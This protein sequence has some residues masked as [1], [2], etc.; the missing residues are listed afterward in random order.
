MKINFLIR[1]STD[2]QDMK[3]QRADIERIKQKYGAEIVRVIPLEGVSGTATLDD[4]QVQQILRELENPDIDGLGL[5]ALDRLF[6]PGKGFGQYV[7][8]DRFIHT[9]K[10]MWTVQEGEVDPATNEGA[11]KCTSAFGHAGAEWRRIRQNT[12][13]GRRE[14]LAIGRPINTTPVY[15]H[16][17]IDRHHGGP[18]YEL[19]ETKAVIARDFFYSVRG[20][21]TPYAVACKLNGAGIRSNGHNGKAPGLWSD[22]VIRQMLRNPAYKG[23][24]RQGNTFLPVPRIV[25]DDVWEDVQKI[26]D[27][28]K[29]RVQGRPSGRYLLRSFLWCAQCTHRMTSNPGHKSHDH[30]TPAY[31]CGNVEPKPPHR[32]LCHAPQIPCTIL[33]LAAWSAIWELLINP[34]LLLSMARAY[35]DSLPQ[36]TEV[37]SIQSQLSEL[38]GHR[39]R[40]I[41]M[42]ECGMFTVQQGRQKLMAMA[43]E[44]SQLEE[45]IRRAGRVVQ[46]PSIERVQ[47]S[48]RAITGNEEGAEPEDY[49]LR[50]HVL[51]GLPDL[52][53]MYADGELEINGQ[54]PVAGEPGKATSGGKYSDSNLSA[55]PST[56]AAIPFILKRRI[57]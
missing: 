13:D 2:K 26:L 33:E 56:F 29:A 5:S 49:D 4:E 8:L 44:I 21:V 23:Q 16:I 11:D 41:E 54:I 25:E 6:R 9:H 38:C 17:Y 15:G 52:K 48:C 20:G 36:N 14:A 55:Y 47:A 30:H 45:K 7:M 1:V 12:M 35:N 50:R 40:V 42:T 10:K 39:A 28:N 3:R 31:V 19:D 18:R 37:E 53:M 22:K 46:L 43:A 32:R 34:E 57:A 27:T 51:E 24:K